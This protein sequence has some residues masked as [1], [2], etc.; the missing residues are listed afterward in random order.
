MVSSVFSTYAAHAQET[1]PDLNDA[2][3][4]LANVSG[5]SLA[6]GRL[7]LDQP[8]S[9]TTGTVYAVFVLPAG[10]EVTAQ[11]TGGGAGI[12]LTQQ[13]G[14]PRL[15]MSA[16]GTGWTRFDRHWGLAVQFEWVRMK[17]ATI[18][19]ASLKGALGAGW[20]K[21]EPEAVQELPSRTSLL[22]PAP[23][24]FNPAVQLRFELRR[25]DRVRLEVFD[26]RG[27]KVHTVVDEELPAGS[28]AYM[29][30]GEDDGAR[31][32]ASGVYF[33]RLQADG[34]SQTSRLVLVR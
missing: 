23:N 11:G 6:W 9:T 8:V 22:A 19:L 24:P 14:A 16:D 5:A 25:S 7:A 18:D 2:G 27:R 4:I 34:V 3:L 31:S 1:A 20:S 28:H 13:P 33:V 15:Y 30:G 17:G 12:G 32:V 21:S 29:W 26:V 10:S